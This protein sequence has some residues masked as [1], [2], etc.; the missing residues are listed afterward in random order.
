MTPIWNVMGMIE[1][2]EEPDRWVVLGNHRD[3]W[4]FGGVDPSSGSAPMAEI[5][6]AVGDLVRA[7]WRP[8]R[9]IVLGNWDAEEWALVGST[10]Y[11]EDHYDEIRN[12]VV[13]YLNVD[14][15]VVGQ[16]SFRLLSTPSLSDFLINVAKHIPIP[17]HIQERPLPSFTAG[18]SASSEDGA[19]PVL[20]RGCNT[21]Y[22]YWLHG[23]SVIAS[24]SGSPPPPSPWSSN[25]GS[26]SDYTPFFQFAGVPSCDL[27]FTGD[28]SGYGV[29]HSNYDSYSFVS[30]QLDPGFGLHK[31]LAQYW[32]AA[33][34][35]LADTEVLPFNYVAYG[36]EMKR[37]LAKF[38]AE[39]E[40]KG[41]TSG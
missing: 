10:E 36:V 38:A 3:A 34:M 32:G 30:K 35:I 25:V 16:F 7:G 41:L 13:A 12:K 23:Q 9:S 37:G 8:R 21:V 14:E 2:S 1:G 33:A 11:V 19:A 29:Y 28:Y 15:A 18:S 31:A 20:C 24:R 22:E 26:G 40:E 6:R 4:T 27:R 5:A 39:V 17:E